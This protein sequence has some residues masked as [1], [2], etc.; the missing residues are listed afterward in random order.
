M[1][2]RWVLP[3]FIVGLTT[4]L[5]SCGAES[6]A[7]PV[8]AG[9]VG[10]HLR[11][12]SGGGATDT[13]AAVLPQPVVVELRNNG[14]PVVGEVIRFERASIAGGNAA[15]LG[16]ILD[17]PNNFAG[18]AFDTTDAN[19]R[20]SVRLQLGADLGM[21]GL[22]VSVPSLGIADT[23][24]FTIVAG[25]PYELHAAPGD[26]GI[27][28]GGSVN[29]RVSPVDRGQ[30]AASG[31]PTFQV[32][33]GP[34]T[35]TTSGVVTGTA[36]GVARIKVQIGTASEI[37]DVSVVPDGAVVMG[38]A[39]NG[40]VIM[41]L[42]Q[43]ALKQINIGG[44]YPVWSPAGDRV[45]YSLGGRLVTQSISGGEPK[46][47]INPDTT[48]GA[49]SLP[50]FSKDGA[51]IYFTTSA[52]LEPQESWRVNAD[53]T[54]LRRIS[55]RP[56]LANEVHP[57]PSP[58]NDRI[59]FNYAQENGTIRVRDLSTGVTSASYGFGQLP[60]WSPVSEQIA[61]VQD[62]FLDRAVMLV[63]ADGTGLKRL[64]PDVGYF[65]GVSWSPDGK[66]LAVSNGAVRVIEVASGRNIWI[67]GK[68][69]VNSVSWRPAGIIR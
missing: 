26:T 7:P 45:V 50:E 46:T 9:E 27:F 33:D 36:I 58:T 21:A 38:T 41:N 65:F 31:T 59:T 18:L 47:F 6:S 23:A 16:I 68:V 17:P 48:K 63:N 11:I 22:K 28:V 64:T 62:A 43:T 53:G 40:I 14:K 49:H 54:G 37:L 55:P 56:S 44:T 30:H 42:D 29:I 61:F 25:T 69:S 32:L 5:I 10:M 20:A 19:G 66:W 51:Y 57:S 8:D 2:R 15:F 13:F 67:P 1:I 34:A 52:D 39:G 3:L 24:R 4:I 35:V 60:S 12:V